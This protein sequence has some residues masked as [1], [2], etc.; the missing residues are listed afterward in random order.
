MSTTTLTPTPTD[1]AVS[2]PAS[3]P[4]DEGR[5][6]LRNNLRHIGALVRRNLLQI[7]KDPESMFDA[8][9]M[10]IVFTLLFVY[11][12]GGSVG[13]SMGGGRQEY[14]NYLIP[15]LMAMMG[16]N[17]A[18]A[19]GSGVNDDFRKGVMDRF[20]TMPIARSSVLIAK[21]VVELGRMMVATLILLAMGFALGMELQ[22]SVLGL[23]GA[24]ALSAAFGAAIMWIFI[25]L[26]LSMKTAQ[27]VQGM[28]MLVMMPLQFGSSI[29]APT[30]TMPGW[31][32]TFTDYNP[33]SNLADSARALMMGGPLAHSVWV[34]LGWTVVITAVMA[35]LAVSKFRKKS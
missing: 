31:L 19:V 26:G 30:Q 16:M 20:R 15:G 18:M 32:R 35:P 17:I 25:L 13:S 14:L 23:I 7:K 4:H 12:F 9:L 28:G 21:I 11:V 1:E 10:P 8:L 3:V 29:F 33:L 2:A 24:I 34:T 22:E 6:G 27:S 5:I